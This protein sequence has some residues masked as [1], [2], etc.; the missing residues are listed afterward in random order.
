MEEAWWILTRECKEECREEWKERSFVV[1][2]VLYDDKAWGLSE[3][4][5]VARE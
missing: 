5:I 1:V 4:F 2:V 3:E